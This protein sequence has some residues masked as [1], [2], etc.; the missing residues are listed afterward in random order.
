MS[1]TSYFVG[2]VK[3]F[4]MISLD[5]KTSTPTNQTHIMSMTL[6]VFSLVIKDTKLRK[7][8]MIHYRND[9]LALYVDKRHRLLVTHRS[10]FFIGTILDLERSEIALDKKRTSRDHPK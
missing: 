7:S 3:R 4:V 2:R 6:G 5:T 8:E 1:K 9:S 10:I